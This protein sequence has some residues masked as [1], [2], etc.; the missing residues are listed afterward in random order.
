MIQLFNDSM[1]QSFLF[2]QSNLQSSLGV[3]VAGFTGGVT[4]VALRADRAVIGSPSAQT[5]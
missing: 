3:T 4:M 2:N 5:V 1:I